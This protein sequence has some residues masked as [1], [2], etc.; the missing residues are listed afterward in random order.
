MPCSPVYEFHD[1]CVGNFS[2]IAEFLSSSGGEIKWNLM[3]I[4]FCD[5][6]EPGVEAFKRQLMLWKNKGYPLHLHGYKHKASYGKNRS[7]F[8]R[9]ALRLTNGEAEFAG[10]GPA[11]S[12]ELLGEA[13]FAWG[14]FNVGKPSGFVAPAWYASKEVFIICKKFGFENYGNRF[15]I[16]NK[17][18][19]SH[20]SVPFSTAGI[21][22]FLAFFVKICEK[23][24]LKIYSIFCFLPIPRIVRHPEDLCNL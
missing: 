14:E 11:S 2:N 10:L 8:G 13:L 16:W 24:Y 19:G 18:T 15:S 9:M 7:C 1:I 17:A 5:D 20:L 3:I 22:K 4:P 21:P 6:K 23:I 12:A